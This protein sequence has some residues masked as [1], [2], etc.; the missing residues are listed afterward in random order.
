MCVRV[1]V[2]VCIYVFVCV[3]MYVCMDGWMDVYLYLC[4]YLCVCL[5]CVCAL[6]VVC[7]K[8]EVHHLH[9]KKG[10]GLRNK[11]HYCN[12]EKSFNMEQEILNQ[13]TEGERMSRRRRG[14]NQSHA[15]YVKM[16]WRR[17]V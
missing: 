1:C 9:K 15:E 5:L 12:R 4:V 7:T 17:N 16:L 2:C 10:N 8:N 14:F 13:K 6:E 11:H 3:C